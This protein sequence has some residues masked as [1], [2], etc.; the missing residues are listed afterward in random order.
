V[1]AALL[2]LQFSL[3]SPL[4]AGYSGIDVVRNKIKMF[5][6]KK[7]TLPPGRHKIII[8]DEAD[9]M[10]SSAQQALRRTIEIYSNTTR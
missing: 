5:A 7:V 6:Q 3:G 9:S 1:L 8:L 4:F 2:Q 10:T